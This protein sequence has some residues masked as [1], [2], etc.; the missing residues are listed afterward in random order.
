[1][2]KELL[3]IGYNSK[4]ALQENLSEKQKYQ[5]L[6]SAR[7]FLF[8]SIEVSEAFG[9]VQ[10]ESMSQR[11]PVINTNLKSGVPWVS[12]DRETGITV[13]EKDA[14]ALALAMIKMDDNKLVESL[15]SNAYQ[16]YQKK[17]S[18]NACRKE[19]INI[20]ENL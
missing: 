20:F 6:K 10:V 1:M 15:G 14:N 16:R 9:I 7:A 8:P 3:K 18:E 19:L 13:Q 5:Y 4:I 12:V 17:F 2:K 11:T